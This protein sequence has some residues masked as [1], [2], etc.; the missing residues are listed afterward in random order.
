MGAGAEGAAGRAPRARLAAAWAA[1][2]WLASGL[3]AG[4]PRTLGL[5]ATST[6]ALLAA[7]G[8]A[9]LS[10][11]RWL[12]RRDVLARPLLCERSL[13]SG[14][15]WLAAASAAAYIALALQGLRFVPLVWTPL[16]TPELETELHR[17]I[18]LVC[19]VYTFETALALGCGVSGLHKWSRFDFTTHHLPY[20]VIVGGVLLLPHSLARP[21]LR[22]YRRT[23]ALNLLIGFNEAAFALRALGASRRLEPP[24]LLFVL[25]ALSALLPAEVLEVAAL[26]LGRGGAPAWLRLHAAA[27]ALAPLLH[28]ARILPDKL[29]KARRLLRARPR[30]PARTREP[31]PRDRTHSGQTYIP[32]TPNI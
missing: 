4:S 23:L 31:P 7:L 17:L 25:S 26:L 22:G 27:C 2:A 14:P 30:P 19:F 13:E 8:C 21:A 3:L 18:L 15:P 16:A 20:V 10:E 1:L 24:R 9:I 12:V 28:A 29:R 32:R 11:A 5:G 6:W